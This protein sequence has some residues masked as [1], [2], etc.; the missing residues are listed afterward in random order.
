MDR[1][2]ASALARSIGTST[3]RVVRAL[4]RLGIEGRTSNGRYAVTPAQARRVRRELG[5]VPVTNELTRSEALVLKALREA[6]LGL[7][8]I[9]A[10]ATRAG[11]APTTASRTLQQLLHRNLVRR[12][13][14]MIAAGR[15]QEVDLWRA[16]VA[17][18]EFSAH[19]EAL[20]SIERRSAPAKRA[21]K[22]PAALRHL[23]W[24]TAPSQ[25]DVDHAGSYIA[26]R[27]LQT[28]D[29]QGLAWGA[30]NLSG[31]DWR[32]GARARNLSPEV[33]QLASNL[34][35]EAPR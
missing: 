21:R 1:L 26:R 29:I 20:S 5:V 18:P 8:S 16:N 33:R 12:D 31:D 9:R 35:A 11:V 24:N 4:E 17:N 14:K 25:L 15:A 2:S 3:P 23:F 19:E 28:K 27:L 7:A 32:E 30:R 13:R 34:A 6:P 10:V 22:V